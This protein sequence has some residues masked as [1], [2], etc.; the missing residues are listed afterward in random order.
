[1]KSAFSNYLFKN[2]KRSP[3]IIPVVNRL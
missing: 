2:T 3:M 1:V